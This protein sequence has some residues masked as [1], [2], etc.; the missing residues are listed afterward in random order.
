MKITRTPTETILDGSGELV[1]TKNDAG[2]RLLGFT[3]PPPLN[4]KVV[5]FTVQGYQGGLLNRLCCCWKL[6]KWLGDIG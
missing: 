1:F 3:E 2:L 6:W 5:G 4:T